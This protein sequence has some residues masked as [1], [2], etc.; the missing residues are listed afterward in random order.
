MS[1]FKCRLSFQINTNDDSNLSRKKTLRF[2]LYVSA[3]L[4][5]STEIYY[6]IKLYY[7]N[8][9][10]CTTRRK[11]GLKLK[12]DWPSGLP[13]TKLFLVLVVQLFSLVT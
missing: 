3:L 10:C 9:L 13:T 7:R 1:G 12:Q 6:I 2:C 5:H 11:Q 8:L 4:F